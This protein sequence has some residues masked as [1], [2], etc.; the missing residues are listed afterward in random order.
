MRRREFITLLGSAAAVWPLPTRAQQRAKVAHIGYLG[1]VSASWHAPRVTAFRAGL[2]DLGHAE[3][4]VI[5]LECRWAEGR[6]DQLPALSAELVRLAVCFIVM[7]T[8]R[9]AHSAKQPTA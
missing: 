8:G 7:H 6:Y 3:G 1:L 5:V 2:R 9:V 4:T